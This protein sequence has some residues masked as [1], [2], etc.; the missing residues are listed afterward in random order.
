MLAGVAVAKPM[1][2]ASAVIPMLALRSV[3]GDQMSVTFNDILREIVRPLSVRLVF[4]STHV[5]PLYNNEI[6]TTGHLSVAFFTVCGCGADNGAV[7]GTG[8]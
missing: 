4:A 2:E 8:M 6:L 1:L 5:D 7:C 3:D